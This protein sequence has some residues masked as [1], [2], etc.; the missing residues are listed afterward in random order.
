MIFWHFLIGLGEGTIT[1][2][3]INLVYQ[4]R[5]DLLEIKGKMEFK[6]LIIIL[7]IS[8][9]LAG[10]LSPFASSLPDGL[11]RV[12]QDLGFFE[13]ESGLWKLPSPFSDYE[14]IFTS[15]P[16]LATAL[17]GIFGVV[18]LTIVGFSVYFLLKRS[19][20]SSIKK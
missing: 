14:F 18:F 16:I 5:P 20:K 17:A 7:V 15:N 10:I 3:I 9:I 4:A 2:A 19:R 1:V 8:L 6:S 13:K 11:E 12:A